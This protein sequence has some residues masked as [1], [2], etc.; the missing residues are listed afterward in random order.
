[1]RV[2]EFCNTPANRS[3]WIHSP[4]G[5]FDLFTDYDERWP[6]G[7]TREYWLNVT[8]AEIAP[9]GF[10]RMGQVVNGT[11]PGPL[12]EA[13]WGDRLIIHITN[14]LTPR[15]AP[16]PQEVD[17]K[18]TT[19]HWHGIRQYKTTESDGVNGVSQCPIRPYESYTYEWQ[20]TQYGHSWYHSH[21]SLQYPDGLY[22]PLLIHGPTSA[23]WDIDAGVLI[24]SDWIHL[25][26]SIAFVVFLLRAFPTTSLIASSSNCTGNSGSRHEIFVQTGKKYLLRIVNTS[27]NMQFLFSVDNHMLDVVQTDFVPITPYRTERLPIGTG[28]RYTVIITA[29]PNSTLPFPPVPENGNFWIRTIPMNYCGDMMP[30]YWPTYGIL[31][32]SNSTEDPVSKPY[33]RTVHKDALP[34]CQDVPA[35]ELRPV[36]PWTVGQKPTDTQNLTVA[37]DTELHHGFNRWMVGGLPMW[38][39]WGDP[40][41]LNLANTSWNPE[42]DVI[43]ENT[44]EAGEWGWVYFII[45]SA[46]NNSAFPER[47]EVLAAHPIHLHGHDFAILAQG[48]GEWDSLD[49][50]PVLSLNNPAR[51]DVALLPATG[52]L[53]IAFKTDNPGIWLMHCHIAWHSSSG[54]AL[55][56]VERQSEIRATVT[57]PD[58]IKETCEFWKKFTRKVQI[59]QVDSG[60]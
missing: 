8:Y 4:H 14:Y 60:V 36:V 44:G 59:S 26:L 20:A 47:A 13:N 37:I 27:A 7:V 35:S 32:Y 39:D 10:T 25:N 43:L 18:G 17:S 19:V 12:I 6:Q 30:G 2:A 45:Q 50:K 48:T 24:V 28:Q 49:P 34:V 21:Y 55:Q 56:I 54:F 51:R 16:K 1:M 3:C 31:R 40:T 46:F 42:Y 5:N 38:L 41:I 58:L 33:N 52:Y 29:T 22:G 15:L 23:N 57:N 11:Y 9:D 53:V